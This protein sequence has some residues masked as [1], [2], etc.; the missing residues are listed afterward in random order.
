MAK[1]GWIVAAALGVLCVVGA[2]APRDDSKQLEEIK[3]LLVESNRVQRIDIHRRTY[4]EHALLKSCD[5]EE[6]CKD[7]EWR[8]GRHNADKGPALGALPELYVDGA[9]PPKY[10]H[11][12][13]GECGGYGASDSC[14]KAEEAYREAN[15]EKV[16]RLLKS[17][18]R[19]K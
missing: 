3:A 15:K 18:E 12:F 6:K 7:L 9:A 4:R 5:L 1:V 13:T 11:P 2:T 19:K 10:F 8:A 17:Y 16:E 14:K